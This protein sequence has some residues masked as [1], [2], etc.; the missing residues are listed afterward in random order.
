M[1]F[2]LSD[3]AGLAADPLAEPDERRQLRQMVRELVARESPPDHTHRL[4][5][6]ERF[7]DALHARLAEVGLLGIDAPPEFGGVGD[8]RDQLV[9]I[10][11]LAAGPTSMAAFLIAQYAVVQVLAAYGRTDEQRALLAK[12]VSG[13]ARV[14]FALSEPDG[15]TDVARVMRTRGERRGDAWVLNGQKMWTSGA[16]DADAV[17]VLARTTPIER[18][19]VHGVTAFLV[20]TDA[21]GVDIRPIDTFGIHGMSTCEVFLT[22][23]DLATEA[24]I[25]EVDNGMRQVFATV[26]RE[27]LNA[28]AATIGVGR[29]ALE[30]TVSYVTERQV[31]GKAIGSFQG[32]Q[33][34]LVD[35]AV[36]LEAARSLLARAAAIEVAGGRS[37]VL[38]SMAKL[39][40]SETAVELAQ[41]GMQLL[42]GYGY[43][44]EVPLQ[45][46]FRD[47]RLW[48]FSPLTNE[49]VRNRIG[50]QYLGLPR[51]Y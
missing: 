46:W 34:R 51:S 14:S 16:A 11:E 24:V 32:P 15:G 37:G 1:S 6:A 4:D 19:A 38:G 29:A 2:E 18:S 10:E 35:G 17:I 31:F 5:E 41:V 27:G 9:V 22:D 36:Q 20:P 7:D 25:G 43:T 28:A 49:M 3:I 12:L 33:H 40:A 26:D 42:G 39:V 23:V 50:E 13:D 47:G 45:R 30:Y 8:V 21:P 44:R 48:C